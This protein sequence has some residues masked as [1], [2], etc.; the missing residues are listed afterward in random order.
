MF[1]NILDPT[2]SCCIDLYVIVL[3]LFHLGS[4]QTCCPSH[5]MIMQYS[6]QPISSIYVILSA[7]FYPSIRWY[8]ISPYFMLYYANDVNVYYP[9]QQVYC[10]NYPGNEALQTAGVHQLSQTY[11]K[12]KPLLCACSFPARNVDMKL[13]ENSNSIKG[14]GTSQKILSLV[15]FVSSAPFLRFRAGD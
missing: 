5:C 15:A 7:Y 13:M 3:F 4:I 14:P 8:I 10:N 1:I 11:H 6:K 9:D 2:W 12:H